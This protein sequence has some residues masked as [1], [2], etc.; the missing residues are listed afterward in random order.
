MHPCA[1]GPRASPMEASSDFTDPSVLDGVLDA[2]AAEQEIKLD[3]SGNASSNASSNAYAMLPG[4]A[5]VSEDEPELQPRPPQQRRPVPPEAPAAAAEAEEEEEEEEEPLPYGGDVQAAM[6]AQDRPAIRKIF[7]ARQAAELKSESPAPTTPPG[8]PSNLQEAELQLQSMQMQSMR[9]SDFSPIAGAG[10]GIDAT[11]S[12]SEMISTTHLN[13]V[14]AESQSR[15][16]SPDPDVSYG[17]PFPYAVEEIDGRTVGAHSMPAGGQHGLGLQY[18]RGRLLRIAPPS[19]E[20]FSNESSVCQW[21]ALQFSRELVMQLLVG[22]TGPLGWVC[23]TC[24]YGRRGAESR[25][26]LPG[27]QAGRYSNV[28]FAVSLLLW[29][30]ALPLIIVAVG[31]VGGHALDYSNDID[32][33]AE[34]VVPLLM[35]VLYYVIIAIKYAFISPRELAWRQK[36]RR[37]SSYLTDELYFSWLFKRSERGLQWELELADWRGGGG[38]DAASLEFLP[39]QPAEEPLAAEE[40]RSMM[41]STA[42]APEERPNGLSKR[43]AHGR[44]AGPDAPAALQRPVG[45]PLRTVMQRVLRYGAAQRSGKIVAVVTAL[46]ALAAGIVHAAAAH[47]IRGSR[48]AG[49]GANPSTPAAPTELVLS[50]VAVGGVMMTMHVGHL[51]CAVHELRRRQLVLDIFGHMLS[52]TGHR[53]PS[54]KVVQFPLLVQDSTHN[55]HTWLFALQLMHGRSTASVLTHAPLLHSMLRHPSLPSHCFASG[56]HI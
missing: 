51:L 23:A 1:G 55:I 9:S 7:A 43:N 28:A 15:L 53:H 30:M 29:L 3:A 56:V 2:T 52:L 17:A 14:H 33:I 12:S 18:I 37:G 50:S 41:G 21:H 44:W 26:F 27:R 40:L 4:A 34:V 38:L 24:V 42:P 6:R 49:T 10:M 8:E 48:D 16:I 22:L 20:K 39:E 11:A 35:L 45:V 5:G 54:S 25:G 13:S 46:T 32:T 47:I 36:N 31:L 19:G